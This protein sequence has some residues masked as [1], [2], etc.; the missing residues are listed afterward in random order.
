MKPVEILKK[1]IGFPTFQTSPDRV[2]EGMKECAR[3]LSDQLVALG[4]KV[5]V[6]DLFNVTGER[7]FGGKKSFLMNTHFD[8]VAPAKEWVDALTPKLNGK[9][10][11]GLGASDAK[12]GIA[13]ALSA[14]S[15]VDDSRF[16]KLIVQFVNYEDNGITFEGKRQLGMPYFLGKNPGFKADYGINIEPTVRDNRWTVSLGCTGR[17]SFTVTTVGKE[18]HSS[19]PL[20]GRNAIYD[21][22]RVIGALKRV[23]P[24]RFEM[25][26]FSGVM[27]INVALI[28]GGRA[29]NIVPGECKITCERR[30]FPNENPGQII[31]SIKRAVEGVKGVDARVEFS[32]N[33]QP[34]YIVEKEH[35]VVKLAVDSAKRAVGYKPML[36]IGLG[37]TDSMYLF[38][39]AGIK[40]VIMGPGHTG[41]VIGE[42]INTDRL[43]EFTEILA[44]MVKPEK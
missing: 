42:N 40:T 39:V 16:A 11:V 9:G 34:P 43:N 38:H 19:T 13:A 18:A 5:R 20:K 6:D 37:R 26:G 21:M 28:E 15:M 3:Y 27:P 14:L 35:E 36:R 8:T 32:G 25:D 4:F 23:A 2:E 33:V 44:N 31:R 24:G 41:H 12:G 29:L 7:N 30:V 22:T 17:V 1:L 10:L